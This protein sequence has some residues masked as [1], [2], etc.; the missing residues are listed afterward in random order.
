[1]FKHES[2]F[3]VFFYPPTAFRGTPCPCPLP[4][5]HSSFPQ[6]LSLFRFPLPLR[7]L[8]TSW[9]DEL[10]LGSLVFRGSMCELLVSSY[11]ADTHLPAPQYLFT[12][13]VV[14]FAVQKLFNIIESHLSVVLIISYI[15][16]IFIST[17]RSW[18]A[19]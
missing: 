3:R 6:S 7:S 2:L 16:S 4:G 13:A 5:W 15:L 1:M 12:L 9:L 17:R 19:P 10:I 8:P 11:V 18:P 14:F